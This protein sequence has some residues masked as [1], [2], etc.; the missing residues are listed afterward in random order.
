MEVSED[1]LKQLQDDVRRTKQYMK[2]QLII[3]VCLVV[4][5]LIAMAVIVPIVFSS[6]SSIYGSAGLMQ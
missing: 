3:T 5:P 6:L 2:W 4:I 1:L